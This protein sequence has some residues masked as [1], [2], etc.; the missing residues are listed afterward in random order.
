[1]NKIF[2]YTGA[3]HIHSL[4]SDGGGNV[5]TTA[6]AAKQAGLDWIII[7]DHNNISVQ[8]GIID[9]VTVIKGEEISPAASNHY[10][11]LDI[12]KCIMPSE[13]LQDAVNAVKEAG[14]F[15]FAAHPDE[16]ENRKNPYKP[17]KWTDK[18]IIP[19]GIEIWNWFSQWADNYDSRNI[20]TQAY[21]YL[22]KTRLVKKP[23]R[24]TLEWFD[25][26]NRSTEKIIPAIGGIDAHALKTKKYFLPLCIFPYKTMFKTILNEIILDKPLEAG[27]QERKKQISAAL[28]EGRNIIFNRRINNKAPEIYIKNNTETVFTGGSIFLDLDT[29]LYFNCS[30]RSEIKAYKNGREYAHLKAHSTR[31]KISEAGKYRIE[32]LIN[33]FGYAYS[34]PFIV[35]EG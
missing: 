9:G 23:Y 1:M 4:F 7:T 2:K 15:G 22:F 32:A 26:L 6:R 13:N 19:D 3:F 8:E 29:Y 21:A 18:K 34:N 5:K 20:F 17:I 12:D 10:I 25:E 28:K 30:K 35:K 33:G 16:S 31:I 14:G 24:I 11:A 27:F